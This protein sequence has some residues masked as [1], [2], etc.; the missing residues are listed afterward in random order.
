MKG[1]ENASENVN[2][3]VEQKALSNRQL[4]QISLLISFLIGTYRQF[5]VLCYLLP[6]NPRT[7]LTFCLSGLELA[8]IASEAER[9]TSVSNTTT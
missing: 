3:L 5:V 9:L 8:R 4:P 7:L 2:V 1:D 6:E